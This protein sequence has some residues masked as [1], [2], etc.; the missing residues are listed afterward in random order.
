MCLDS[1][2]RQLFACFRCLA[3]GQSEKKW[4]A[5]AQ[6]RPPAGERPQ[7]G[8]ELPLL[9]RRVGSELAETFGA[10]RF[11]R[12]RLTLLAS[13]VSTGLVLCGHLAQQGVARRLLGASRRLAGARHFLSDCPRARQRKHAQRAVWRK[14]PGTFYVATV[15]RKKSRPLGEKRYRKDWKFTLSVHVPKARTESALISDVSKGHS[16][17]ISDGEVNAIEFIRDIGYEM[18]ICWCHARF[19]IHSRLPCMHAFEIMH[20]ENS[21]I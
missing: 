13:K 14:N 8:G 12:C 15:S 6:L 11:Y 1:C 18:A 4:R 20:A 3:S 7:K 5:P 2:A 9:A 10:S 16:G 17:L 21:E 19:R